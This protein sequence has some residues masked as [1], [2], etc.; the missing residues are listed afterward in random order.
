DRKRSETLYGGL[1]KEVKDDKERKSCIIRDLLYKVD[2]GV[3]DELDII[4][5][6]SNLFSAGTDT[7]SASLTRITAALANNPQVQFKAHQELDQVIGQSRL[8]NIFDEQNIPYIRAI[9]K[10]GQRYCGPIYL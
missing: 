3:L 9:V 1:I 5:I 6:I 8:P 7:V 4:H 10:E 2:D